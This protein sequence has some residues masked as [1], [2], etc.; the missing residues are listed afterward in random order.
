MGDTLVLETS[1]FEHESSNLSIPTK[2]SMETWPS[3]LRRRTAN[4]ECPRKAPSVRI[5]SSP[6]GC[7][8]GRVSGTVSHLVGGEAHAARRVQVQVL[9]LP[10][11]IGISG[12]RSSSLGWGSVGHRKAH[13]VRSGTY[14]RGLRVRLAPLPPTK[15]CALSIGIVQFSPD[16]SESD[17]AKH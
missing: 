17:G 15:V 9:L 5:G 2:R 8:V 11:R 7:L 12:D 1:A 14:L 10:P 4:A 16:W 13:P 3:G 6:P